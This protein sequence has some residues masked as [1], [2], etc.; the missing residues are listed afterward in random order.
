[1]K[2][3]ENI[4]SDFSFIASH[5]L[6]API[7]ATKWFLDILLKQDQETGTLNPKQKEIIEEV[8]HSNEHMIELINTIVDASAISEGKVELKPETF[9]LYGLVSHSVTEMLPYAKAK[10]MKIK[11]ARHDGEKFMVKADKL[12]IKN[13]LLNLLS[14]GLKYSNDHCCIGVTVKKVSQDEIRAILSGHEIHVAGRE[15]APGQDITSRYVLFEVKD[16]GIGIPENQHHRIFDKFYRGDNA[17]RM[18][19]NGIGLGL[20][21]DS[22]IAQLHHGL[23]WFKSQE[24]KGS[25]FSFALP[26]VNG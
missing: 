23:M 16:E 15:D 9:D 10:N 6:K 5:E 4:E 22:R 21:V 13:V 18:N 12:R 24:G 20:F 25:T 17:I 8:Y 3:Q 19:T 7:S 26:L 14:N 2:T 11:F 1:M